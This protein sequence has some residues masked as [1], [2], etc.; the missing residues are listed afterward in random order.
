MRKVGRTSDTQLRKHQL[1]VL[2]NILL[3]AKNEK[4]MTAVLNSLLTRSEKAAIAQ[5]ICIIKK[6]Q[7]GKQY[8]EIEAELGTSPVTISKSIDMYLKHG[9]EN[10]AF[11][12]VIARYDEPE[13][14]YKIAN[15]ALDEDI[16]DIKIGLRSLQRE[17]ERKRKILDRQKKA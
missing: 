9:D 14:N 16:S 10:A 7:A 1:K 2:A 6:I 17:E 12:N 4:K 8:W 11:N 3:K 5:R 13:L 15:K